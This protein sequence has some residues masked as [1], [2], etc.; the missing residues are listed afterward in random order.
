MALERKDGTVK[1]LEAERDDM[2]RHCRQ[3]EGEVTSLRHANEQ[4]MEM[5]AVALDERSKVSYRS[6]QG[7]RNKGVKDGGREGGARVGGRERVT[8]IKCCSVGTTEPS[9]SHRRSLPPHPR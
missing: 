6:V 4:T 5:H 8:Y 3:L 2:I 9:P 7:G 1:E